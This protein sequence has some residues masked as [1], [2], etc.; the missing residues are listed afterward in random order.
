MVSASSDYASPVGAVRL[1]VGPGLALVLCDH[2]LVQ[3][4]VVGLFSCSND[5]SFSNRP[6]SLT[7]CFPIVA[8]P[9]PCCAYILPAAASI[10]IFCSLDLLRSSNVAIREAQI[11]LAL[12]A[13]LLFFEAVPRTPTTSLIVPDNLDGPLIVCLPRV[14]TQSYVP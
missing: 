13:R 9:E 1:S 2:A 10:A 4:L 8:P 5:I 12:F 6:P 7:D 11:A 3:Q 14:P